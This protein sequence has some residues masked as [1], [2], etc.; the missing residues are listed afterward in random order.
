MEKKDRIEKWH[1]DEKLEKPH[2]AS[3]LLNLEKKRIEICLPDS[4]C[5][6]K[7]SSYRYFQISSM[8]CSS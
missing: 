5:P 6:L 8:N 2:S 7:I 1:R 3:V 4:N